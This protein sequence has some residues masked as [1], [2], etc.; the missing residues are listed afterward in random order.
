MVGDCPRVEVGVQGRRIPCILDTGSQVSLFSHTFFR[1][2]FGNNTLRGVEEVPWLTLRAA[3]GLTIPYLGYTVLDFEVGGIRLP[4]K[5][6][7]IV[8][9]SCLGAE[10]GILG[11]NVISDCWAQVF[12]GSHPGETAFRSTTTQKAGA[13]WAKAFAVCQKTLGPGPMAH[14]EGVAK[15]ERQPPVVLPPE[16]EMVVWTR[17]PQGTGQT[18]CWVMVEDLD[19][20]SR[21]WRVARTL[22]WMRKGR[23]ALRLCNP[24]PFP[25]QLPQGTPL[26]AVAQVEAEDVR[27]QTELVFTHPEPAVVEVAVRSVSSGPKEDHP[28]LNLQGDGLA[29]EEQARLESLLKKWSSVFAA[30]E[31]DFGRT[32]MVQHQIPTGDAPPIRERH[33]PVPPS[34]YAELRGLLR[35]MLENGVVRE[36]SSP[37]AAPVVLV[38]KKDGSWRFCVD[39][40]KLNQVTH[41]D[42]F[43][44]PR[45][46]ESLTTLKKAAFYSTL[47][48]AC[49]YWQVEVDPRDQEKTAFVTPLGLYQFERMPFGLCNAPATFQ[50]LMQRCLGDQVNDFL[51]I[52]LDDVIVFSPSFASHLGHLEQVFQRLQTHGLK[53]QPQKCRLFQREVRYLGHVVSHRGVATD[54]EKTAAVRDWPIPSNV[55]QVRSF[56]GFAGYYRRFIPGFSRIATPLHRLLEGTAGVKSSPIQ[57]S[58][59]C[60]AAFDRLK[61]ALLEAPVLAYADFSLPFRVYVDASLEGLGAVLSQVQEGHERVIAYASRSLHPAERNDKNYSSFKLELLGLKW[62]I[63]EKFKDYLWGAEVEIFTDNNPLV[64]LDTANLGATE[65]RWAAQL[66]NFKYKIKYRPGS[67]N[68]NADALSRLPSG[69]GVSA[70]NTELPPQPAPPEAASDPGATLSNQAPLSYWQ[71]VQQADPDLQQLGA[72]KRQNAP[73]PDAVL[74]PGL[75]RW[76]IEWPHLEVQEG[77]LLRRMEEADTG[78]EGWQILVPEAEAHTVWRDYH[79]AA[80][81]ANHDRTLSLLRRRFFWPLMSRDCN[82]FAREC[83][84]CA[85]C[86]AGPE[87][88]APLQSIQ[89]TYPFEVVGL[90]YLSLG[91]SGDAYPYILVITDLFSRYAVAV[92]TRDQSAVTTAKALWGAFIQVFGCPERFLSDRGGAFESDLMHQLCTLYGCVKSRTTPYHP[93]GNGAVERFNQTLL[94]LL[95]S[96]SVEEQGQWPMRLP[97]LVQAYN[98]TVHSTTGL[99]PH[100]VVFGRHARLPV[101]LCLGVQPPQKRVPLDAW[102]QQHH[103]TLT[104]A[105]RHVQTRVQQRQTWDQARYNRRAKAAPL[106]VGERV[107]HR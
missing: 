93:Q 57:W 55:K 49:G 20:W 5:G 54:P 65:Q 11:M 29:P 67:R 2:H 9:D 26:A 15:L 19:D 40:R 103:Q 106:L 100:F 63:T 61:Q 30:H 66:A 76:M 81:H 10:C 87:V 6:V 85:I 64:H 77:V 73:P 3:N 79:R 62:A 105:Y 89:S 25:V 101:D 37:W 107:L 33:R 34:L 74:N 56:L 72:W 83:A 69:V 84:Q 102:V 16:T 92:P 31:D 38:R 68:G 43:P 22:T 60:Q 104:D 99:T 42:A 7:V 48:L 90:D 44:L 94:G 88:R 12:G 97:A 86:K 13:A 47:D 39:Y 95:S 82:E 75:R 78:V 18:D 70:I 50:R 91:R 35:G 27:S 52:Y 96:L 1:K 71:Q 14:V 41:K 24:N 4:D 59:A 28:A 58:E 21:E 53:L 36:S 45:I 8:Q 98:N 46:E 23:V 51:L 32:S 17:V 80:G